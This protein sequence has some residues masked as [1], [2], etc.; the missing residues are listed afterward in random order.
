MLV[1]TGFGGPAEGNE[2]TNFVLGGVGYGAD[3]PTFLEDPNTSDE[4]TLYAPS[5]PLTNLVP[6]RGGFTKH[7][8]RKGDTVSRLAANFGISVETIRFA[9]PDMGGSLDIGKELTIL[10]V[11]GITYEI[12]E[13]DDIDSVASH[14]NITPESIRQYNPNYQKLFETTGG[15]IVLPNVKPTKNDYLN[16]YIKGLPDLKS[17]FTLPAR[18]WNWGIL[19]EYNAVDIADACGEP[20]YASAEGLV[21]EEFGDGYWNNGYGNYILIEHPNGTKTRYAHTEKNLVHVGDYVSQ[22]KQIAEIGNTGN[23]HGPTG[24]HLHFEVYGAKNPFAIH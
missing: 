2:E 10:P 6:T 9:N 17:Y 11:S 18:G 16:Q 14:Y 21:V 20:I 1:P 19:H 23:T 7:K 22:G 4:G 15:V 12:Q 3:N 8:T 5:Y 13:G 24:C